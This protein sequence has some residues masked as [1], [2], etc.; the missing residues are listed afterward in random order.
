MLSQVLLKKEGSLETAAKVLQRVML[1]THGHLSKVAAGEEFFPRFHL[2]DPVLT[3]EASSA[4]NGAAS[5]LPPLPKVE[6]T[7][8]ASGAT[9][10]NYAPCVLSESYTGAN[11]A[12]TGL[13]FAPTLL[14]VRNGKRK[15]ESDGTEGERRGKVQRLTPPEKKRKKK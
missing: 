4:V 6:G 1:A 12:L 10:F 13:N 11:A 14:S 15:K 7:M 5:G 2:Q 3:S 8:F 9:F